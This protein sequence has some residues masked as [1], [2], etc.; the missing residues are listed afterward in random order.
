MNRLFEKEQADTIVFLLVFPMEILVP[1]LAAKSTIKLALL[2]RIKFAIAAPKVFALF[3][4][5]WENCKKDKLV[6]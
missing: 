3:H 1:R 5:C 4:N 2:E 6:L